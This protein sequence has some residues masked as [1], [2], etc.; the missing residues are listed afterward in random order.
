MSLSFWRYLVRRNVPSC[1]IINKKIKQEWS[2]SNKRYHHCVWH[3]ITKTKTITGLPVWNT[4]S[5]KIPKGGIRGRNRR[6]VNIMAKIKRT[7]NY[8]QNTTQKTK[9]PETRTSLKPGD[10]LKCL[11]RKCKQFLLHMWH[12][13]C[14]SGY[15]PGDKSWMGKGSVCDYDKQNIFVVICDKMKNTMKNMQ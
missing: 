4:K 7:N 9:D 12:S 8:L 11:L 5:L 1:R 14:Y 15:S 2:N 13:S 10:E 3:R 6:T